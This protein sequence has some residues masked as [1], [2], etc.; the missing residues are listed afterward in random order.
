MWIPFSKG[1][2]L[3]KLRYAYTMEYYVDSQKSE[4]EQ[5]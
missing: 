3:K 5:Y 1:L 2:L 4:L